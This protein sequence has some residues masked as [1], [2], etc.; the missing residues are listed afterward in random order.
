MDTEGPISP[1]SQNN[2]Y[3][4]VIF[5]AFSHFVV[6]NTAHHI[7]SKYTI[8]TLLHHWIKNLDP[9]NISLLTEVLN[10]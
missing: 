4:F 9:H 7:T 10:I 1:S 3:I 6:T 5:D 8:Q 2:S